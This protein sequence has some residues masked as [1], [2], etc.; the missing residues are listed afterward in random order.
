MPFL[1]P[2]FLLAFP[3]PIALTEPITTVTDYAIALVAFIL[4]SRLGRISWQTR[5]YSIGL[6][7]IAFA[8]VAFAAAFGGTC[9]GFIQVLRKPWLIALWQGMIYLLSLASFSLL[10]GS[11]LGSVPAKQQ[12]WLLFAVIAKTLL[13]GLILIQRPLFEL[14][15]LDYGTSLILLLMLQLRSL[16]IQPTPSAP[17]FIAGVLVSGMALGVLLSSWSLPPLLVA[18][19]LY[20]LVQLLGLVLLYQGAKQLRDQ[21]DPAIR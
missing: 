8:C 19:D 5:Q 4:A 6:W 16:W 21:V 11:V 10:I 15:V 14:A 3:L 20:H 17:G 12:R 13:A 1:L 9:H 18:N 2:S 7:A